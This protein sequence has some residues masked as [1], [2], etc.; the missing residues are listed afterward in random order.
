MQCYPFVLSI[1]PQSWAP[2]NFFVEK[3]K[4]KNIPQGRTKQ[5]LIF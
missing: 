5:I 3:G 2:A 1:V 4:V